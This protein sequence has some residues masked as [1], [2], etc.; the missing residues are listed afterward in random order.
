MK[1]L[2]ILLFAFVCYMACRM[3]FWSQISFLEKPL[4]LEDVPK[5][6]RLR[7]G[8]MNV[9]LLPFVWRK[10]YRVAH[11]GVLSHPMDVLVLQEVWDFVAYKVVRKLC[12]RLYPFVLSSTQVPDMQSSGLMVLSRFPIRFH[13]FLPFN[14]N[15]FPEILMRKGVLHFSVQGV[16]VVTSHLPF[17]HQHP[18]LHY[19]DDALDVLRRVVTP[20]RAFLLMGDFN[21]R[22]NSAMYKQLKD[23]V[24]LTEDMN[25]FPHAPVTAYGDNTIDYIFNKGYQV[26]HPQVVDLMSDDTSDHNGL[27]CV[28]DT[29]TPTHTAAVPVAHRRIPEAEHQ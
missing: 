27:S 1:A 25:V 13:T 10:A 6:P 7:V 8:F 16:S 2:A 4:R 3:Y 23:T 11:R 20:L 26:S 21:T 14:L 19:R 24:G 9:K 18:H 5:P 29:E 15:M 22:W 12:K 17:D 28:V